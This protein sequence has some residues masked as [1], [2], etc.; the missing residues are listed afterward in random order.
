VIASKI[1]RASF[2]AFHYGRILFVCLAITSTAVCAE[3]LLGFVPWQPALIVG[4]GTHVI[5]SIDNILDWSGERHLLGAI[6][7]IRKGYLIWCALTVPSALVIAAMLAWQHNIAF[8]ALLT[9]FSVISATQVILTRQSYARDRSALSLWA[10]RLTDSFMWSLIVVL[11]PVQYVDQP[12]VP[13]VLMTI[14]YAWHLSWINVLVWDITR[15]ATGGLEHGT[16]ILTP[17]LGERRTLHLMRVISISAIVLASIDI[18]LGYFPW[19]NITVIAAPLLNLAILEY[20]P[21]LRNTPRFYSNLFPLSN[22]ISNLLVLIVYNTV[23][24]A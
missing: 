7:P 1:V 3:V 16:P 6:H 21:K 9:S 11:A 8:L 17:L 22:I 23:G 12:V 13:Q 15:S 14:A 24:R 19:Y 10:E 5:Y 2:E 4:L 20:W 18:L